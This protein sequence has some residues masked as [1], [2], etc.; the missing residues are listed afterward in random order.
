[1][2]VDGRI[3]IGWSGMTSDDSV[4]GISPGGTPSSSAVDFSS[5]ASPTSYGPLVGLYEE[6]LSGFDLDGGFLAFEPQGTGYRIMYCPPP[7]VSPATMGTVF[8]EISETGGAPASNVTVEITASTDPNYVGTTTTD[9][10]GNYSL[11]GVPFGMVVRVKVPGRD[12]I[13][14]GAIVPT[15]ET[16]AQIDVTAIV[17]ITK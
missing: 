5:I 1:M 10:Q 7:P 17:P 8:G 6:W 15:T 9:V 14:G 12:D 11:D 4:V 13:L 3:F 16:E 2:Y